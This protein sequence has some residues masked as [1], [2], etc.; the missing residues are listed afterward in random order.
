MERWRAAP[1]VCRLSFLVDRQR[2]GTRPC[3]AKQAQCVADC[4][5]AYWGRR[6]RGPVRTKYSPK[7]KAANAVKMPLPIEIAPRFHSSSFMLDPPVHVR[8]SFGANRCFGTGSSAM[9]PEDVP[10]AVNGEQTEA[11]A[12]RSAP[13]QTRKRRTGTCPELLT[14]RQ[15]RRA[16]ALMRRA[17]QS[18]D[19]VRRPAKDQ[20]LRSG[21]R[22]RRRGPPQLHARA[23]QSR[24]GANVVG[25][26]VFGRCMDARCPHGH[27]ASSLRLRILIGLLPCWPAGSRSAGHDPVQSGG[28]LRRGLWR[29]RAFAF[30]CGA[31]DL[32]GHGSFC[33]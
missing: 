30:E 1:R 3:G 18:G 2:F 33:T 6:E 14:R 7:P 5:G 29:S 17:V 11:E 20:E 28:D 32:R 25:P 10:L 21:R 13:I 4:H 27:R 8:C 16:G 22:R 24:R 19:A 31:W 23:L 12:F 9:R 26:P 15:H